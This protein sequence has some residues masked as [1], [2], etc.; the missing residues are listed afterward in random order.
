MALGGKR[1]GAGRKKGTK[2]AATLEKE[3][4]LKAFRQRAMK[5]AIQLFDAQ[6]LVAMGT[7]HLFR[8]E[9]H[10]GGKDEHVLVT[11]EHE[12]KQFLDEHGQNG[13]GLIEDTWYYISTKDPDYKAGDSILDRTFGKANQTVSGPDGGPIQVSGV[14]IHVRK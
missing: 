10:K 4:V 9:K 12:I 5:R 8:I 14:E 1:P 2:N 13:S 7:T 11:N 3:A 6:Y